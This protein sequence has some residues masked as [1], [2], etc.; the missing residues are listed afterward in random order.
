M[1]Q[2]I[3]LTESATEHFEKLIRE[4]GKPVVRLEMKGGGCAGFQYEWKMDDETSEADE[5]I[6]INGGSFA[7]DAMSLLYL[8]GTTID[9]VQ[10]VFGSYLQVINPN[11]TSSCGCGESIGF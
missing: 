2:P 10:E 8:T 1:I 3:T 4:Q 7:V 5:V 9:Y 11:A 6:E